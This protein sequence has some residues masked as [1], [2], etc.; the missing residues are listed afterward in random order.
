M[1]LFAA[2]DCGTEARLNR[3]FVG[4]CPSVTS[5]QRSVKANSGVTSSR[6][7]G[8]FSTDMMSSRRSG[9]KTAETLAVNDELSDREIEL[10]Q[11]LYISRLLDSRSSGRHAATWYPHGHG[12]KQSASI[13][14]LVTRKTS[15]L[16]STH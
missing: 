11:Q 10:Q 8:D 15:S 2:T 12:A 3:R 1:Y 4:K 14:D 7:P 13:G 6:Q 9:V 5:T 16:Q